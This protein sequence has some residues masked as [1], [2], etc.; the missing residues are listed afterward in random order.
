MPVGRRI[1][2]TVKRGELN[3]AERTGVAGGIR[4]LAFVSF[5]RP[6]V[7]SGLRSRFPVQRFDF[8][9]VSTRSRF[10]RGS[11]VGSQGGAWTT[12]EVLGGRV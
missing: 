12:V 4:R 3:F 1:E 2:K 9:H 8:I 6:W 10:H 5:Q 7:L 11:M